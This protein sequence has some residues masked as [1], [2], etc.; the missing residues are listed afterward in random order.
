MENEK[1]VVEC[2][3]CNYMKELSL[4]DFELIVSCST[5]ELK[6]HIMCP[7]CLHNMYPTDQ[8]VRFINPE[9]K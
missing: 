2:E 7:N 3:F 9:I 8:K 6:P 4:E 5:D 1:I